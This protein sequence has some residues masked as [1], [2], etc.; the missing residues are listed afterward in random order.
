M[1]FNY[2]TIIIIKLIR[3]NILY[4]RLLFNYGAPYLLFYY[5]IEYTKI[6]NLI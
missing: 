2:L 1:L 5:I 4:F 6:A 3:I